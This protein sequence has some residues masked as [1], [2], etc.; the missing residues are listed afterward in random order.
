MSTGATRVGGSCD[1]EIEQSISS[2]SPE[3][4]T[5]DTVHRALQLIEHMRDHG[6][7]QYQDIG[8]F[9]QL[10][11]FVCA[12]SEYGI[13]ATQRNCTWTTGKPGG[14]PGVLQ[15]MEVGGHILGPNGERGWLQIAKAQLS[16]HDLTDGYGSSGTEAI[17]DNAVVS[18]T[19]E[20][21]SLRSDL[22]RFVDEAGAWMMEQ[23][24]QKNVAPGS[25]ARTGVR[26]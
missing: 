24:L 7:L 5:P 6:S 21:S 17:V 26:L 20:G 10:A 2:D 25:S 19:K 13:E 14:F 16:T 4:D 22:R 9:F 18:Y 1:C 8:E 11:V 3:M 23:S 15:G 12:M